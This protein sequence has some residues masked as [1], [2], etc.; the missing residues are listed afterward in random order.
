MINSNMRSYN[1]YTFG[2]VDSYGQPQ[3]SHFPKGTI[4]MAINLS[5]QATTDNINYSEA[6]YIGLTHDAKVDDTY[7]IENEEGKRFKVLYVSPYGRY[8]QVYLNECE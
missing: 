8:K 4:K 1:F 3:L 6:S 2:E 7:V 5:S